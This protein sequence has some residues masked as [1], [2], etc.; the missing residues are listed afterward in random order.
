MSSWVPSSPVIAEFSSC[1]ARFILASPASL[2]SD[3]KFYLS[4]SVNF[5]N[6][7]WALEKDLFNFNFLGRS[8]PDFRLLWPLA[9]KP[10]YISRPHCNRY[11]FIAHQMAG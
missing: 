5:P 9:A 11:H 4:V 3:P 7:W 1:P 6:S 8:N 10:K 2:I